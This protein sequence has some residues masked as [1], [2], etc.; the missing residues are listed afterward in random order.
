MLFAQNART[1]I[2]APLSDRINTDM[3][4]WLRFSGEERI[5]MEY[6][7]GEGF[8]PVDDAYLM[9]R[10]RLNMDL[11]PAPWLKFSFQAEDARVFGQ[12]AL[13][14]PASQKDSMDFRLGYV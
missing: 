3:P 8:K 6:I 14:A 7:V 10:L 1:P 5:R 12:N 4:A 11:K 2:P 9:N 13:P